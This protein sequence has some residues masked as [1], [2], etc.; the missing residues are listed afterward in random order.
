M[1]SRGMLMLLI[2]A[3]AGLGAVVFAA[4]W[5]QGQNSGAGRIAVAN[6][7][8]ALGSAITPEM[9]RMVD[10]PKDGVPPGAFTVL[11]DLNGRVVTGSLQRGE[12]VLEARLAPIGTK[13]GLSAVVPAGKRAMTVRV[14]DVVGVA[15]FALPGTFVDVMVN[16]QEEGAKTNDRDSTISK[17]VLDRILVLAVAQEADRDATKPKV[18][19]AVTLEVTPQQAEM[20]D[21]AR[22]VG[23]LSLVL[24]NQSEGAVASTEGATKEMLLRGTRPTPAPP[25]PPA[26]AP[27]RAAVRKATPPVEVVVAAPAPA[28]TP[29]K[30]CVE[31]IRGLNKATECF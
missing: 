3:L 19:N 15:G 6:V 22:S 16:T 10:W 28:P 21:L 2:A 14:N 20:L 30:T 5:M 31:I 11:E 26:P 1:R 4:R 18:V 24:R 29:A 13:G 7:E 17:I 8:I 27:R 25:P 9:V 23:T 12:P